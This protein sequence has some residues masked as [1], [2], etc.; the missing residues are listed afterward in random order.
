MLAAESK[1]AC[2]GAP[3]G[4]YHADRGVCLRHSLARSGKR[5]IKIWTRSYCLCGAIGK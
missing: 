1:G 4:F 3:L 5:T 2:P